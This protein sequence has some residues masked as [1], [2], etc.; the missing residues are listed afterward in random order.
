MDMLLL[1]VVEQINHPERMLIDIN[2]RVGE[3]RGRE[4]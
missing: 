1:R 4:A 3:R 2:L